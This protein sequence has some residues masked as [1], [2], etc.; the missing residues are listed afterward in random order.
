MAAVAASGD[1]TS[2]LRSAT[3]PALVVHRAEDPVAT[4]SGG[5][6]TAEALADSE[7]RAFAGMGHDLPVSSGRRLPMPSRG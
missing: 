1:R 5:I 3:V 4:L 2:R 6:A 7:L